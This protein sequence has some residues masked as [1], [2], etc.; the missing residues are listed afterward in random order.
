MSKNKVLIDEYA[1]TTFLVISGK[2]I[3]RVREMS[4]HPDFDV[5]L[6]RHGYRSYALITSDNP[7]S[8]KLSERENQIRR[9]RLKT[10]L[11]LMNL[12]YVKASSEPATKKW[13]PEIGFCIFNISLRNARK[14]GFIFEQNAIVYGKPNKKPA[15]P[16]CTL[17]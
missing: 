14:I 5:F 16:W 7:F 12:K 8:K 6:T 4:K 10:M 2:K 15:I 13:D 9:T 11:D 17:K 1:K 3:Y